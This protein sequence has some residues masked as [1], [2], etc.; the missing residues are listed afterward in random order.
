MEKRKRA[1]A[2][3]LPKA[4]SEDVLGQG[5]K[6]QAIP[7]KWRKQY[8]YLLELREA[9]LRRQAD[10]ANDALQEKPS[11]SMHMADAGTDNYDRDLALGMLSSEQDAVYQI[12]QA[13]DRIR[14][15]TYG[16]CEISGK[17][18]EPERLAVIPWTRFS[19]AASQQLERRGDL[20]HARLGERD[21]VV[22]VT[23]EGPEEPEP[24]DIS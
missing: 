6:S 5:N 20:K 22:K 18:I 10:L 4:S 3:A 8:G 24:E 2:P 14:N 17:P 11:F 23:T 21:S 1:K 9:L 16:I 13:L 12:E 15:G 7:A 19:V